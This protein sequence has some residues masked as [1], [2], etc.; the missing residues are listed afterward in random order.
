[1]QEKPGQAVL[2]IVPTE[3]F[4]AHDAERI[5]KN[6]GRKLDGQLIIRIELVDAILS[7]P[8]G[9][10]IYVDQRIPS[11]FSDHDSPLI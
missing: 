4:T 5:R 1:M 2:R 3:G 10:A 9:K 8:R 7:S 11:D 6:L